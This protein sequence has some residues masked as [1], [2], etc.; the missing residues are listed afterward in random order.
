MNPR[1]ACRWANARA[2]LATPHTQAGT[3]P[4][5][6]PNARGPAS[7]TPLNPMMHQST[8]SGQSDTATARHAKLR[9]ARSTTSTAAHPARRL[10]HRHTAHT[11][12]HLAGGFPLAAL[13]LAAGSPWQQV[14]LTT[15]RSPPRLSPRTQPPG[16]PTR[17]V[18]NRRPPAPRG[19]RSTPGRLAAAARRAA[20]GTAAAPPSP[21]PCQ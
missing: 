4:A 13:P 12:N 21:A 5:P 1:L 15:G 8:P 16:P 9:P 17:C 3:E 20:G 19:S 7:G 6:Q 18:P 2:H 14:A 11:A 10:G